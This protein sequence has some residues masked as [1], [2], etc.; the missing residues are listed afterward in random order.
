MTTTPHEPDDEGGQDDPKPDDPAA[1]DAAF[2]AIVSGM[3]HGERPPEVP[4]WPVAEDNDSS[5]PEEVTEPSLG[6]QWSGWEDVAPPAP[7]EELAE[8]DEEDEGEF[9]P[10]PPP[11]IPRGDPVLRWA[12]A[13][14]L[15]A[16]ALAVVLAF[17]GWNFDGLVGLFLVVAFLASFVTL[18]ARM[19][20]GPTD[21]DNP[22]DG[23]VI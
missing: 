10:P 1:I 19:R 13:G 21:A 3:R 2:D 18:I 15:G 16:P 17:M 5:S 20:S 8:A 6:S 23:A 14:A 4:I 22:D 7:T 9:V 11:P 12:W